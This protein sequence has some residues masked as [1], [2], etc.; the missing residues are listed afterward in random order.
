MRENN[1]DAIRL[2]AAIT[3]IFG[4]A[5]PLAG[6]ASSALLANS[7][8]ALAVKI[9]FVISGYLICTSWTLDPN[10]ARYL[11]K[12]ALRIFPALFVIC[13]LT[14]FVVGPLT[15]SLPIWRY[16]SYPHTFGYF[17]N[18][19]LYP[20]YDLPGVFAHNAYPIAVNGSL[21]SLPVEFSMYLVLPMVLPFGA[22]FRSRSLIVVVTLLFCAINLKFVRIAPPAS[23]P[24]FY[25]S[26][27]ISVLDVAPYFM[28][29]ALVKVCRLERMLDSAIAL[30]LVFLTALIPP[31]SAVGS[32]LVL[33]F[34]LPYC[35]LSLALARHPLLS[36]AGRFGDFP[37]GLYLYGFLVQ[38]TVNHFTHNTL[39]ALQNASVSLPVA[40]ALA[41]LSWRYVEKPMLALKPR[42]NTASQKISIKENN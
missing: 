33:F 7:V 38:Q 3:V 1:F 34:L 30:F 8:Q 35:T 15:T 31:S 22:A 32:E 29:G 10:P 37:Y 28:L 21:W 23:H 9:F 20:I 5:H 4:H 26:D 27:L 24:V 16:F 41:V 39:S 6:A 13:V 25:G 12:R 19:L 42:P 40:L 18:V 14:V 17:R 11:K 36:K 2:L